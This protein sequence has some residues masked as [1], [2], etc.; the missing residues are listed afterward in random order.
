MLGQGHGRRSAACGSPVGQA[1]GRELEALAAAKE[2]L[3]EQEARDVLAKAANGAFL[4]ADHHRML[5]RHLRA[6]T[7]LS[8][9]QTKQ[10]R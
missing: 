6:G 7:P 2:A 10:P 3:A 5:C 9:Q 4:H 1:H 8:I